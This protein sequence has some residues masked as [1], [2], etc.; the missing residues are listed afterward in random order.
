MSLKDLLFILLN[1]CLLVAGQVLWKA[2]VQGAGLNWVKLLFSGKIW[3]GFLAFALATFIWFQ[4]LARVPLSRALPAQSVAYVLGVLAGSIF[5]HES[6]SWTKWF[7]VILIV[8]GI[9]LVAR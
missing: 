3:A 7:G 6:V 5:F 1:A 4:V 9:C 8:G 2:G